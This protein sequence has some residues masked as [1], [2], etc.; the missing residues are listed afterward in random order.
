MTQ[1]IVVNG[2]SSSGK[3]GI[4][5]CLQAVLPDPW[6]ALGT[7]TLVEAM[8]ASMQASGG[9]EFAPDGEVI[10]GPE[11]RTL[12]AAWIAGVAAMARAG[13][14][15][16]VD[17]VFLGGA[18][19][20]QRWQNALGELRVLW[21]GVRCDAAVAAG[22][23]VA[24][25]DRTIGMAASQAEVVHQGVTYD[26]EVDTTHAEAMECARTIAAHVK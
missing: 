19:S 25:G 26:L 7:D 1:V 18:Y 9:I 12:E 23:E 15:V 21:V 11:F 4:V 8:P 20:Q 24:R 10:V 2:G 14:R 16:I 13:A 3:S 17:E 22:R 5:R 6:L